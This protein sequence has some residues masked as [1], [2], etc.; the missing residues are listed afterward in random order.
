LAKVPPPEAPLLASFPEYPDFI[1]DPTRSRWTIH[2]ALTMTLGTNWDEV[3]VPYSNPANSE[4]AMDMAPDR[5]RFV[6]DR[7]IV[8]EP[9]KAWTY[10][11]GATA[12]LARIIDRG[13]GKSLH[14]FAREAMFDPLGIGPTDWLADRK[15]EAFAASGLR[16][17]PR[18]LAR[19][20]LMMLG[21]G[22]WQGR[23]VVPKNWVE[24]STTPFVPCQWSD[25]YGYHWYIGQFAVARPGGVRWERWW[26][27]MGNGGQRLFMVPERDLVVVIT[28]GNYNKN[29]QSMLPTRIMQE[30]VLPTIG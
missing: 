6:L 8:M 23:A 1:A 28:A 3:T 22:L 30:V 21:R 18:D 2:Q 16:M 7:P 11:G 5:Y 17:T 24:R 25:S 9:G 13:T 10:N 4:I 26:G 12:L 19:I 27:A 14:A 20:G 15:G 29:D